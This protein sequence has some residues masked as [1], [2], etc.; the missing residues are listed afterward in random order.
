MTK[1]HGTKVNGIPEDVKR[2]DPS[3]LSAQRVQMR[4]DA[5]RVTE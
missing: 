5:P 1:G 2:G 3:K 4:N